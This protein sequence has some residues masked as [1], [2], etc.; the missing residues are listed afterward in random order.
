[1]EG[2]LTIAVQPT[3]FKLT[4]SGENGT[5]TKLLKK[6]NPAKVGVSLLN[7]VPVDGNAGKQKRGCLAKESDDDVPVEIEADSLVASDFSFKFLNCDHQGSGFPN[8]RSFLQNCRRCLTTTGNMAVL[9]ST[10]SLLF[11]Q[12]TS[13]KL[14]LHHILAKIPSIPYPLSDSAPFLSNLLEF[15][16]LKLLFLSS[17]SFNAAFKLFAYRSAHEEAEV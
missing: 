4:C 5:G 1:M 6:S 12:T 13:K 15:D 10:M 3:S 11:G 2:Y 14:S 16:R 17:R 9:L 8:G 7:D